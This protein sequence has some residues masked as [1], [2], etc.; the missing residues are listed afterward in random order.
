MQ[1]SDLF[2][3]IGNYYGLQSDVVENMTLSYMSHS[4]TGRSKK[5]ERFDSGPLLDDRVYIDKDG[6]G[7]PLYLDQLQLHVKK[8]RGTEVQVD[9]T[10]NT[11][12]I[13]ANVRE[14]G[15]SIR[16]NYTSVPFNTPIYLVLDNAGG[17]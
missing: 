10:C 17:H 6:T 1:C 13:L 7:H 15:C 12:F 11:D 14:I 2:D 9:V 8:V 5:R 3:F 4:Y 16:S